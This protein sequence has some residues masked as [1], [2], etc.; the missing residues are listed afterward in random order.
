MA[1]YATEGGAGASESKKQGEAARAVVDARCRKDAWAA[2]V[3]ACFAAWPGK[4]TECHKQLP[5]DAQ[6][7]FKADGRAM[8]AIWAF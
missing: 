5:P 3:I 6:A 1:D 8:D 4:R 7:R 2:A